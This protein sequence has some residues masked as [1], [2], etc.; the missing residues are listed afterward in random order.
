MIGIRDK[1]IFGLKQIEQS[2]IKT[3][4]SGL[5]SLLHHS[6]SLVSKLPWVPES[7]MSHSSKIKDRPKI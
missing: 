1:M 7:K 3:K 2:W 4:T 6:L 5:V